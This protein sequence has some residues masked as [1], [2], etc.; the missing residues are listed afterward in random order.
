MP[1]T[2]VSPAASSSLGND[3]YVLGLASISPHLAA[4]TSANNLHLISPQTLQVTA[5]IS[6][7]HTLLTRYND[8][9]LLT[10]GFSNTLALVDPRSSTPAS[11][12]IAP[13]EVASIAVSSTGQI[14]AGTNYENAQAIVSIWDPRM[15]TPVRSYNESH[16]DDITALRWSEE[17]PTLLAS[18]G[19][20]GLVNVFDTS[21]AAGA[22]GEGDDE[23]EGAVVRV[24]NH[25]SVHK[26]GFTEGDGVWALSHDEVLG[27][28][29][30]GVVGDI[31]EMMGIK[32]GVDVVGGWVIAGKD[33]AVEMGKLRKKGGEWG[34]GK[35]GYTLA[36]GHGEEVVRDILVERDS[37]VTG[38]EDGCVK[39]WRLPAEGEG[40]KGS[41]E[42]RDKGEKKRFTPY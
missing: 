22:S 41:K 13:G 28:Y 25:G 11:T 6:T 7:P 10:A 20:D 24:E 8:S 1:R 27:V 12:L 14:A 30:G 23:V 9:L 21:V 34:V 4:L 32:Y 19:T 40:K 18:G 31:R 3:V 5:T 35:R 15:A 29:D 17:K 42:K 38:G 26:V 39:V 36:G 16:N 37:V 2:A 33:G